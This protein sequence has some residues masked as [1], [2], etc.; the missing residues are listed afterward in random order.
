MIRIIVR[1]SD[2]G[3]AAHVGG[4]VDLSF[5]TFDVSIPELEQF[6]SEKRD[7]SAREVVGVEVIAWRP[8]VT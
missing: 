6:L 3:A 5:K 8:E 1:T 2:C 4:P 7:Y